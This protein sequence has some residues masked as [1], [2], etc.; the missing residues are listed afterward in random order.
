MESVLGFLSDKLWLVFPLTARE[1]HRQRPSSA[2]ETTSPL[3]VES[4]RRAVT[5]FAVALEA[6]VMPGLDAGRQP[7]FRQG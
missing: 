2:G 5:G 7:D 1:A 4:Y 3:R 6:R